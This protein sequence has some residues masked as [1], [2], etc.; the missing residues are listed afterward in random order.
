MCICQMYLTDAKKWI[1]AACEQQM[2][3]KQRFGNM[4]LFA[5]SH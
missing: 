3:D 1:P 2:L 4:C 5:Q